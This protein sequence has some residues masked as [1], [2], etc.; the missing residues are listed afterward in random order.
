[1]FPRSQPS[2]PRTQV[3]PLLG[4]RSRPPSHRLVFV[5]EGARCFLA[6][7]QRRMPTRARQLLRA[8]DSPQ[9]PLHVYC[10]CAIYAGEPWQRRIK[11]TLY[12][13]LLVFILP[14]LLRAPSL[15]LVLAVTS[16]R[17]L[18]SFFLLQLGL[19]R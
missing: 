1:M 5:L 8:A 2:P 18:H 6:S 7:N 14:P 12:V 11:H 3:I 17:A 13:Q 10:A 15:L 19:I 4:A 16:A 9:H